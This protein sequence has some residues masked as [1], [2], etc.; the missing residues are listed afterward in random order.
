LMSVADEAE[1]FGNS[2]RTAEHEFFKSLLKDFAKVK[3]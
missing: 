1:S 3:V 2:R